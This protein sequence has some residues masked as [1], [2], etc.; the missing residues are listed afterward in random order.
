LPEG[1]L[2]AGSPGY[3]GNVGHMADTG[4]RFTA[5]TVRSHSGEVVEATNLASS[6]PF[7]DYRHVFSLKMR[8]DNIRQKMVFSSEKNSAT[9][10]N[11]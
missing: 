2:V 8:P 1:T 3:Y 11:F 7:T 6:K 9:I 5:E 4:E 10:T